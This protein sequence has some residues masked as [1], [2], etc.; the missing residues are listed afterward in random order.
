VNPQPPPL[1]GLDFALVGPGRVGASLAVWAVAAG[2]RCVS[3]AGKRG[4]QRATA[5]AHRLSADVADSIELAA[6]EAR[7]IWIAVPDDQLPAVAR[8]LASQ[9]RLGTALHV[10]GAVGASVLAPL[11]AAGCRVGSFHPLR[12][13]PQVEEQPAPGTFYALDGDPEARALGRR[14]AQAFGG[15]S[16][17]VSE[18]QRPLYHWAATLAAGGIV[19]LLA[20]AHAVGQRLGLPEA[21][22]RGYGELARGAL[23]HALATA[24]PAQAITGP[25]ARGDLETIE[26]HLR[27]LA[28]SSP[29][30]V[31]LA[32]HLARATLAR[33]GEAVALDPAQQSLAD[34]LSRDD[35]LD[36]P[37]DRVLVSPRPQPA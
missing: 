2:A 37:K 8:R 6:S 14:V 29:D 22:M 13:F 5:L 17:V 12:A 31:P 35:L 28:T 27:A 10:S 26:R 19:T 30:L 11:A 34:R 21:A 16:A 9:R 1:A 33:K 15:E 24:D 3:V 4:S 7:L 23:E 25:A 32:V 36:P 20:T 18:E